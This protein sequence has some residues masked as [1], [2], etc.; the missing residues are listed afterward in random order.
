MK[1]I[2]RSLLWM[3]TAA[4][5]VFIAACYGI[6][7]QFTK[8]GRVL[9]KTTRAGIANI[10]ISCADPADVAPIVDAGSGEDGGATED[11]GYHASGF[12]SGADGSFFWGSETA[13]NKLKFEDIDGQENGGLYLTKI[14]PIDTTDKELVVEMEKAP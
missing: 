9:D 12:V 4:V 7:Y 13:C 10:E 8:N 5:P 14:E 3:L 11:A 1:L 2:K 6:N